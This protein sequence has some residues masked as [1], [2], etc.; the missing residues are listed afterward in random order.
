MIFNLD[1]L[2]TPQYLRCKFYFEKLKSNLIE[3]TCSLFI[4]K[5]I[6]SIA[7]KLFNINALAMDNNRQ[8]YNIWA[9]QYDTNKNK[10]RD[11]EGMALRKVLSSTSFGNTLEIGCG[12]GK[13]S[14]WLITQTEAVMAPRWWWG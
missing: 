12:T 7:V 14:E 3:D 9:D 13:N 4:P 10:T 8:A 6:N 11:L 5:N 1:V 2:T